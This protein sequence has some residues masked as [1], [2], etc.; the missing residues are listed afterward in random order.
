MKYGTQ[1]LEQLQLE[2]KQNAQ[3]ARDRETRISNCDVEWSD[4]FLSIAANQ[5]S[6]DVLRAKIQILKQG[7][8][9]SFPALLDSEGKVIER[10]KLISGRFGPVWLLDGVFYGS[11]K[12]KAAGITEGEQQLPAW[13]KIGATSRTNWFVEIFPSDVNY[14]TGQKVRP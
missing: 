10:A 12:M 11:K 6:A 2:L 13:A 7:G 1:L 8:T 14:A 4:C 3:I 5:V 9:S